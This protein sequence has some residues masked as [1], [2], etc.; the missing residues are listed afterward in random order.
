MRTSTTLAA[1]VGGLAVVFA[2][3][4]G[5]GAVTGSPAGTTNEHSD[6]HV[7]P[8]PASASASAAPAGLQVAQDG[9]TLGEID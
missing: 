7:S 3:A 8:A 1:Y 9:Y 2:T 6:S 4:L 5:V